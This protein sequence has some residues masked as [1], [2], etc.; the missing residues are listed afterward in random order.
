[1][2]IG[3]RLRKYRGLRSI[4][5]YQLAKALNISQGFLSEVE[6]GKKIP[7]G[8]ILRS[9]KTKYPEINLNWLIAAEG[10]MIVQA[11]SDHQ[12]AELSA[13]MQQELDKLRRE[14]ERL[15]AKIEALTDV[16]IQRQFDDRKLVM[17]K[18]AELDDVP[19]A[20]ARAG[21]TARKDDKLE[22]LD[23][24]AIS[25]QTIPALTPQIIET[26]VALAKN[27]SQFLEQVGGTH[28]GS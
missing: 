2:A 12:E 11:A 17:D 23:V 20:E 7:G 14:N 27:S 1:M 25:P 24:E 9:L 22:V 26:L 19:V 13:Q 21:D 15:T 3:A 8:D 18:P 28:E 10:K 5:Q 4:K 6:Q 16:L